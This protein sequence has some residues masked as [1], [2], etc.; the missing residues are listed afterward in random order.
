VG[1]L[2]PRTTDQKERCYVVHVDRIIERIV[3]TNSSCEARAPPPAAGQVWKSA[4]GVPWT[5]DMDL[6]RLHSES[7]PSDSHA[8]ASLH[9]ML[10]GERKQPSKNGIADSDQDGTVTYM[11]HG[12]T[13]GPTF[14]V[15]DLDPKHLDRED[16]ID[17]SGVTL[18]N[19]KIRYPTKHN[20]EV[21]LS[22]QGLNFRYTT[23]EPSYF[24]A[25]HGRY[26]NTPVQ[27]AL[28]DTAITP[29]PPNTRGFFYFHL[30]DPL[31]PISAVLRFRI[32]E[33]ADLASF[34]R[35]RDLCLPS[36]SEEHIPWSFS[37]PQH[38]NDK[39]P[40]DEF[41]HWLVDAGLLRG[42]DADLWASPATGENT[43]KESVA[44]IVRPTSEP[45][46]VE[47]TPFIVD[48]SKLYVS[49]HIGFG[50]R[51]AHFQWWHPRIVQNGVETAAYSGML[52]QSS[53][54]S[55]SR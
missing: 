23:P 26:V 7:Q 41:T 51:S 48:L 3:P 9:D 28:C 55:I 42:A 16:W 49:H 38:I 39:G 21:R 20:D 15:H 36:T 19:L 14:I 8:I 34:E 29:F 6:Q 22:N 40:N 1:H 24:D 37:I 13:D 44:S 47:G 30:E 52:T 46:V 10:R 12:H 27:D 54:L 18:G 2:E 5:I 53:L 45:V 32:T 50:S 25:V 31:H 4:A 43:S 17:L 11:D 35:G 33:S